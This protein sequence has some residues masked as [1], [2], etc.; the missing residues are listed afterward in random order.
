VRSTVSRSVPISRRAEST[1]HMATSAGTRQAIASARSSIWASS[2]PRSRASVSM[3]STSPSDVVPCDQYERISTV[4]SAVLSPSL[5]AIATASDRAAAPGWRRPWKSSARASP[6][7][8]PT[9][10]PESS[11]PSARSASSS[12]STAPRSE[13]LGRQHASS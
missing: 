1:S 6:P 4:A 12:S 10:S 7:S 8:T 9:R 2:S 3:S 5:R 11:S 13:T